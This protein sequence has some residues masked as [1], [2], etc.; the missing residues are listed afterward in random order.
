MILVDANLLI[1]AHVDGFPLHAGARQ[2]LDGKLGGEHRVGLPWPS[3]LAFVRLISNPRVFEKPASVTQAWK[4]VEDW[5]LLPPVWI[6]QPTRE[7]PAILENLLRG[8]PLRSNLIPDA[9]LAAIAIA[10]GLELCSTDGD[11]ARFPRLR[12]TNPLAETIP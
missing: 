6:P 3:L 10:H 4:Q 2:W 5:L 8:A 7:H 12:W 9:H 1:Y 11:F